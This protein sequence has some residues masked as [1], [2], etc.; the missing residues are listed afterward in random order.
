MRPRDPELHRKIRLLR[1]H[2]RSASDRVRHTER[3]VVFTE[4]QE[5]GFNYRD[6][7]PGHC[8][9]RSLPHSEA[10]RDTVVVFPLFDAMTADGQPRLVEG[11]PRLS[12]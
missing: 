1:Q 11:A 6:R 5:V 3:T 7:H 4:C 12:A 9:R 8:P 2:A 10:A